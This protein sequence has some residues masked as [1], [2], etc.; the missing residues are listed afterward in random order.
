MGFN[1]MCNFCCEYRDC[2]EVVH[3]AGSEKLAMCYR[4]A[5]S[6]QGSDVWR[7]VREERMVQNVR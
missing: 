5:Y 2:F 1:V 6:Y 7:E 4:C 3:K